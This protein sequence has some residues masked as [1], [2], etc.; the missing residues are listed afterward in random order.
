MQ[1]YDVTLKT[2]L[3]GSAEKLFE[4]LTGAAVARWLDIELPK[5]Q[6]PRM[7]L[8]A[9]TAD[10]AIAQLELQSSN[11]VEMPLRMAE[12]CL[13]VY[14]RFKQ[15]PQQT[16]LYV[17]EPALRMVSRLEG[18][19][20]SFSYELID[21]RNLDSERLLNSQYVGDNVIA[22]LT[23]LGDGRAALHKIIGNIAGLEAAER[24]TALNQLMVLSGLR[25]LEEVVEE[26][27]RKMP[28]LNDIMDHKVLGREYKRGAKEEALNI[29]RRLIEKRF[30]AIPAWAEERLNSFPIADLEALSVRVLEAKSLED[31]L[32]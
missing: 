1:D 5:I 29:S 11:D 25:G 6:N 16:V 10:G 23:R 31:L 32:Q 14:R 19:R 2:L 18:P 22:I 30:G 12:Y 3:R 21:I 13:G 8:L 7:D 15:F 28:I 26:E 4:D 24:E 17:G 9:E 20:L 27:I